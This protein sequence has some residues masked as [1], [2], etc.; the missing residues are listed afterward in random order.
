MAY[1]CT[2]GRGECDGC[3]NCKPT[4]HYYCPI[5]GKEALETV[6]LNDDEVIGCENCVET[7]EPHEVLDYE[8][9]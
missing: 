2:I 7:R 8:T 9:D 4:P 5:C 3:M 1:M 6:Y